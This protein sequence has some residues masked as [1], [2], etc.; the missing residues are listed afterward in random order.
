[1]KIIKNDGAGTTLGL[2]INKINE[3]FKDVIANLLKQQNNSLI[4]QGFAKPTDDTPAATLNHAYYVIETGT[5]FGVAATEGQVLVGNDTNWNILATNT[6]YSD[7]LNEKFAESL[8]TLYER[9]EISDNEFKA[10]FY[11]SEAGTVLTVSGATYGLAVQAV[12]KN[13]AY[14]I[15]GDSVGINLPGLSYSR[16]YPEVGTVVNKIFFTAGIRQFST[17]F[18]PPADGFVLFYKATSGSIPKFYT[19]NKEKSLQVKITEI[20]NSTITEKL[21]SEASIKSP[22]FCD[23][24][25]MS[26]SAS[27]TYQNNVPS[28]L[29][30]VFDGNVSKV[31]ISSDATVHL[32]G[33]FFSETN[34]LNLLKSFQTQD[35]TPLKLYLSA[36]IYNKGSKP[37]SLQFSP[38][39]KEGGAW[40]VPNNLY[41]IPADSYVDAS[42][43]FVPDY[44]S[45]TTIIDI[46]SNVT[47][48][49]G[50][51]IEIGNTD[52]YWYDEQRR[53]GL[54]GFINPLNINKGITF[55]QLSSDLQ[56]KVTGE[57]ISVP[58]TKAN[59]ILSG[60]SITWGDG[61]IDGGF[62][63][64][65]D[66]VIK[67]KLSS[68]IMADDMTYAGSV[69]SF[70]NDVLY[71]SNGKQISGLGSKVTFKMPG[72][73]IAICQAKKRTSD[74]GVMTV[75][76]D[77]V[78]IGTFDNKNSIGHETEMFS[79]ADLKSVRLKH[80]ATFNHTITINGSTQLSDVEFY[81]GGYG[82]DIGSEEAIVCRGWDSEGSPVHLITFNASLGTITSV[83]VDY[84]YG[85][86]VAHERS[87]RG[88]TND[89]I[90]NESYYGRGATSF[91]PAFPVDGISSGMEFRAIDERAFFIYKF[92]DAKERVFEIEI[93][94][95]VNPYFLV[96]YATNRYHNLMNA[97]IGG[98]KLSALLNNDKKC[99][100]TQFY[101]WFYPDILFQESATNDDW[102]FPLRRI[103]RNIGKI[104]KSELIKL[105]GLEVVKVVYD[106][107]TDTYDVNM[108]TGI[109]SAITATSLVSADIIGTETQVGDIV[110]IGN[111][112]GD[113][114]QVVCRKISEVDLVIGEIKWLEPINADNILN[115]ETLSDLVGAEINIRNLDGY[116]DS[117]K[118]L[119]EKVRSVSPHTKIII[120]GNG[121]SM[122]GLRQ[123]W[124]YNILHR[125]LCA[126]YPYVDF[127]DVTN[128][129][130]DG[131]NNSISGAS[132][133]SVVS[134]GADTYVLTSKVSWQGFKV[135]VDGVDV[136][137]KDCYLKSGW[138]YHSDITKSGVDLNKD[139]VY[140]QREGSTQYYDMELV[141]TKNAPAIGKEIIVQYA[142]KLWSSDYCHP[143][144]FGAFLYGQMYANYI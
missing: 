57:S 55:E 37:I 124:G 130:Y 13:K 116:K 140:D 128:W 46:F 119:I 104:M 64:V 44:N 144:E 23:F 10:E 32:L 109:I 56:N 141:F 54:R 134:T 6:L 127:C 117:Y 77:G 38:R 33:T 101:K 5:V 36:R 53:A 113:N 86:I 35:G 8:F 73:E 103:S 129:L 63:G 16:Y 82:G 70:L 79:G 133:E 126:E 98:W 11:V 88:Q 81:T 1:M 108:A 51:E 138:Y 69:T 93:T 25:K 34:W 142:D 29:V 28:D 72:N 26:S 112:Y 68:T 118:D 115:V 80:P 74:Y 143:Q 30:D 41:S 137:G 65:V 87:T 47:G 78:T 50:C 24:W 43:E 9:N 4:F 61:N 96:N 66:G 21:L 7:A 123:L 31:N 67:K 106:S 83:T 60:S 107:G 71:K 114:K 52:I 95:G 40:I 102:D 18:M 76:A 99:D 131:Q 15:E 3:N 2:E 17:Y 19:V 59:I 91:D 100:Y 94:G 125:E 132:S 84:D 85:R 39:Y 42:V 27:Y 20:Q 90:T 92:E 49:S 14:L 139:G 22:N 105:Q 110:R 45:L 135:L 12:E 58:N 120:V 97:G 136:Y 75:R 62:G 121:L 89:G 122:Y 111:Y 48:A